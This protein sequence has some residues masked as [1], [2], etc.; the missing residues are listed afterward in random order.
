MDFLLD[1]DICSAH[2]RRAAILAHRFV[3]GYRD[4]SWMTG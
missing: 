1:P 2:M 4:C 3:Q